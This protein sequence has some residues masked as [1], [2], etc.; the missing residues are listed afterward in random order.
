MRLHSS[1]A[2]RRSLRKCLTRKPG[3]MSP[4]RSRG[5]YSSR[6]REPAA[7]PRMAAKNS[8]RSRPDACAYSKLSQRPTIVLAI[9]IWFPAFVLWPA[10]DFPMKCG[11][12]RQRSSG[13]TASKAARSPPTIRLS[14]ALRA[15]ASPPETGE[16]NAWQ[17][18]AAAAA[19]IS[20][21]REGDDVVQSTTTAPGASALSAPAGP[22]STCR[23]S[24]GKPTMRKSTSERAATARASASKR[25]PFD[26]SPSALLRVL[27]NTAVS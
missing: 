17:P 16:S 2:M 18:H 25:A 7:P 3:A 22:S 13:S 21:A 5:A 4:L 8:S 9:F 27:L 26:T 1:S 19:A 6:D 10:P 20:R 14:V 12:P 24:S 15:P 23:T 11:V